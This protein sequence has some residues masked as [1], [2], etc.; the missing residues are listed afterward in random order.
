MATIKSQRFAAPAFMKPDGN[1]VY[2]ETDYLGE[3]SAVAVVT[4]W[5][6]LG[7]TLRYY[8]GYGTSSAP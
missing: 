7:F 3:H 1:A 2:I 6:D 8:S 4:G 5:I